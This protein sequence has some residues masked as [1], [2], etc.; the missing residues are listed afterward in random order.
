MA[1]LLERFLQLD[2]TFRGPSH[3]AHWITFGVEQGFQ[4]GLQAGIMFLL[5]FPPRACASDPLSG[6]KPISCLYL[7]PSRFD[8]VFGD[9]SFSGNQ[10]N[11][12]SLL[13][14]QR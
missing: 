12:A 2:H 6:G 11:V 7:S 1:L 3:Q 13:G 8:R 5:L 10:E 14:F 4:I 9:P